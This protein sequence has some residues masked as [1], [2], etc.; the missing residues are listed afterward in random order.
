MG[1]TF[2]IKKPT[3]WK[4]K[5]SGPSSS[6]EGLDEGGISP[7]LD[8][9]SPRGWQD[10]SASQFLDGHQLE[11]S[12]VPAGHTRTQHRANSSLNSLLLAALLGPLPW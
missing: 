6:P 12:I 1:A 9:S 7:L 11:D 3:L 4:V 10:G 8:A 5:P 2:L